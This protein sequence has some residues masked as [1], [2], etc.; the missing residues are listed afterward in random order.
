MSAIV[1]LRRVR[2]VLVAGVILRAAGWGLVGAATVLVAALLVDRAAPLAPNTRAALGGIAMVGATCIALALVVRDRAVRSLREVALWLE[3]H[4]PSLGF[5]LVSA[6]EMNAPTLARDVTPDRWTA[7]ALRR[8]LRSLA[9]PAALIV[10]AGVALLLFPAGAVAR[11]RAPHAGD[12]LDRALARPAGA[13]RLEPL[14]AIV[15]PP[16]Y[17]HGGVQG[18]DEPSSIRA[19][20]GSAIVLRG[21]GDPTGIFARVGSDSIAARADSSDTWAITTHEPARPDAVRL[22]DRSF[23]KIVALEPVADQAPSVTLVAP[24][25]DTVLPA[26]R[27][28]L[29][30]S[31]QLA[32]DIGLA[33]G[34]FELIVSSG[35][36]EQFTSR[37]MRLGEAAASGKALELSVA[38]W[39]DSLHLKPGDL[40]HIRAVARDGNDVTGPGLG[41]SETRAIRIAR[42]GENDSVAVEPAPPTDEDKSMVSERMLIMLAEA[43]ERQRPRLARDSVVHESQSIG[44]D[45]ARLRRSVGDVV[46]S[47][48]GGQ[49]SGEEQSG[50]EPAARAASMQEML[51]R[52]DSATRRAIDPTDFGGDETPVVAVNGP[53]LEAYNAMWE[54][55]T[56]LEIGEPGRALPHMRRALAAIERARQAERVYLHGAAPPI[57]VDVAR[58]RL[59]GKDHGSSSTRRAV[60]A[61]SAGAARDARFGR[62]VESLRA[63]PSAAI[64]SL[65]LLRVDALASAPTFAGALGEAI[66]ALRRGDGVSASRALA[67]A[68]R[69]LAGTPVAHDSLG[70]WSIVP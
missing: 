26:P 57:I 37:S 15:Q 56:A 70:R 47:R 39:L 24:A 8:S 49:P 20:V 58:A 60:P 33:S 54:A 36:G 61:D 40:L 59:Q 7:L 3:A 44:V 65:L 17:A 12:S 51:A 6:V 14:V 18:I 9:T 25:R 69:A 13:S 22:V 2:A 23:V 64:D 4:V 48:L 52:A 63:S 27:G 32:D 45:Q 50:G 30:L 42:P 35:E 41:Y 66:D 5:R 31:A 38:L 1:A 67:A 34:W 55:G 68:R 28:R 10:A 29:G 11:L 43:L 19:L 46:F 53:L 21:R 62:I 16:A